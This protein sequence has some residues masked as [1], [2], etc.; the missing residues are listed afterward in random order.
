MYVISGEGDVIVEANDK[1]QKTLTG[2]GSSS[3]KR[4][5]LTE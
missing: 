3:S 5:S 4:E 1:L 2:P